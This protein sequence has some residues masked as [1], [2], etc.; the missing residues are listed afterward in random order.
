MGDS[1]SGMDAV[2]TCKGAKVQNVKPGL[3]MVAACSR[4]CLEVG[5]A[6]R[7]VLGDYRVRSTDL[8]GGREANRYP[9][10]PSF[11]RGVVYRV[12]LRR[13][14]RRS[15]APT[16]IGWWRLA[17]GGW[18]MKGQLGWHAVPT[19]PRCRVVQGERKG[20]AESWRRS[21]APT[22]IGWW[23]LAADGCSVQRQLGWHAVPTLPDAVTPYQNKK[24]STW[25]CS[26]P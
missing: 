17:A 1:G 13:R 11:G 18:S 21:L 22:R 3:G 10:P 24:D 12:L 19:L 4:A 8:E 26:L 16:S 5:T 15:L 25:C 9:L 2:Q 20:E 14:S 7:A 23:R 6:P